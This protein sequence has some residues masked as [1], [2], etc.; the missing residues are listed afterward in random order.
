[1]INPRIAWSGLYVAVNLLALAF[2]L[3]NAELM[4]DLAGTTFSGASVVFLS[5][6]IVTLSIYG[7]YSLHKVANKLR[8]PYILRRPSGHFIDFAIAI[9][10]LGFIIFVHQ[11]GLFVAGSAERGGDALSA[12]YVI[13][14]PDVLFLIYYAQFRSSRIAK[15][16]LVIWCISSIQ[17]GW[18]G[19]IFPI[20]AIESI[21]H[22]RHGGIKSIHVLIL[23]LMIFL[24]PFFDILKVYIRVT[25]DVSLNDA[26]NV[27]KVGA[28]GLEVSYSALMYS[29]VERIVGRLQT[30]S[31]FTF[32]IDNIE[33]FKALIISSQLAPFWKEGIFGIAFDK[34]FSIEHAL[35]LP[36]AFA[37]I[38]V[39][40]MISSWNV[41]PSL[42][43]WYYVYSEFL[44]LTL[45]YSA[46]LCVVMTLLGRVISKDPVFGDFVYF[47]LLTLLIPGWLAQLISFI[48]G[49]LAY[50]LIILMSR[51][52]AASGI[53]GSGT[54]PR[55]FV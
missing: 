41:N 6:A 34:I 12:L 32:I 25:S 22:L 20:V 36:Q 17:R 9:H 10:T 49:M 5:F 14:N 45:A 21:H 50:I 19:F 18:F 13:L 16:V 31:H 2:I 55:S 39:P 23:A 51:I 30:I 47:V 33:S 35:E 3:L 44:P 48:T 43:G 37:R 15:L 27:L 29:A 53:Q 38:L 54:K 1:M 24:F 46:L 40:E 8:F 52:F 26:L 7:L 11:T 4:G 42:A 28:E